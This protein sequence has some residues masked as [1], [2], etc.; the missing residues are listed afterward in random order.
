M[1]ALDNKQELA[2]FVETEV[3]DRSRIAKVDESRPRTDRRKM[4]LRSII[5]GAFYPRRRKIRRDEDTNHTF[6]DYHPHHLL[7]ISTFVLILSVVDGLFTVHMI[8]AGLQELNPVLAPFVDGNPVI[9]AL[10]KIFFTAIGVVTLV[11]TA[12]ARLLS[13]V[14]V[15]AIFYGL[16]IA[17][18]C[19]IVYHLYL[20]QLV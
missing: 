16:L 19:V 1:S 15:S 14:R 4:T 10:V 18:G 2:D 3:I 7:V 20:L 9:F 12:Q 6:V 17:Y 5:Y 11:V 13:G 8:N